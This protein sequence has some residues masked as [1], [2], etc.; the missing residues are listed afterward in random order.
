MVAGAGVAGWMGTVTARF[1]SLAPDEIVAHA[2]NVN[3]PQ[4]APETGRATTASAQKL[5]PPRAAAATASHPV[6]SDGAAVVSDQPQTV[7][8][9]QPVEVPRAVE[10]PRPVE[11][12]RSVSS[13]QDV[14]PPPPPP[15]PPAPPAPSVVPAPPAPP[16]PPSSAPAPPAPPSAPAPPAPP[17]PPSPGVSLEHGGTWNIQ[18]AHDGSWIKL[19]GKGR[20]ELTDD[21]A[22]VK[23]LD[24]GGVFVLETGSGWFSSWLP[25]GSGSRFEAREIGGKIER[26]YRIDGR[27]ADE[28]AGKRWLAS[29][30]PN[31]VRDFAIGA[32]ARVAR[33]LARSGPDGVF[34]EIAAMHGDFA[35]RVSLTELFSQARLD[36]PIAIRSLSIIANEIDSDFEA[37]QALTNLLSHVQLSPAIATAFAK[38]VRGIESDFEARQAL[39]P[40]LAAAA[41]HPDSAAPLLAAAVPN[42]SAGIDSDFDLATLLIGAPGIL[43][44]A[45]PR[46]YFAAIDSIGSA[47]ERRR[48]LTPVVTSRTAA[49]AVLGQ[50]L[51]AMAGASG[52]YE[53]AGLLVD[54]VTAHGAQAVQ[55]PGFFEAVGRI[56]SDYERKRVLVAAARSGSLEARA[57]SAIADATGAMSSD[58]ERAEVLMALAGKPALPADARGA[59]VRAAKRITSEYYRN[60]VLAALVQES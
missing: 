31:I 46:E 40:A 6:K 38:A 42:G 55:A 18:S 44:E 23:A 11:T 21:D 39:T 49:P 27:D 17:A 19:Q 8:A 20:I 14:L 52:D 50:A 51:G 41:S 12:P 13:E 35:R 4:A 54:S 36:E 53:K 45:S 10:A 37:R 43:V 57:V 32:P 58:Y 59:V 24:P 48:A 28:S 60:R 7:E 9:P 25:W 56:G 30:L 2:T 1:P 15:A 3:E 33:I 5:P 47:Y 16:A 26:R 22:D 29:V 34:A